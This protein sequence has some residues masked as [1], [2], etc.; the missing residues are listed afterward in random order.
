MCSGKPPCV[1]VLSN[2]EGTVF[3]LPFLSLC[4]TG[5]GQYFIQH[6]QKRTL[7]SLSVYRKENM[8]GPRR[9]SDLRSHC[10]V[11]PKTQFSWFSIQ[12]YLSGTGSIDQSSNRWYWKR[13]KVTR[14]ASKNRRHYSSKFRRNYE[15]QPD[16]RE[17]ERPQLNCEII[18]I[19]LSHKSRADECTV[20]I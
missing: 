7:D 12:F 4:L 18:C 1:T 5:K 15:S 17:G 10:W 20:E 16:L 2:Q 14:L 13:K 9:W 19:L 8:W 6:Q 11:K 3:L